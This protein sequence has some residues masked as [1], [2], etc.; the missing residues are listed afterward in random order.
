MSVRLSRHAVR[1]LEDIAEFL[2]KRS[3]DDPVLV[4]RAV[5]AAVMALGEFPF[6]GA[7]ARFARHRDLRVWTLKGYAIVYR[8][9][10]SDVLVVR[11]VHAARDID[12][13]L[14]L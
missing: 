5:E 7:R 9:D 11:V 14:D 13:L 10:R 4:L 8:V 3:V 12:A 6:K 2:A 1:D